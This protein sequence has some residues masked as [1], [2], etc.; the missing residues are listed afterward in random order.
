[1]VFFSSARNYY[2]MAEAQG[3]VGNKFPGLSGEAS[4]SLGF[5]SMHARPWGVS[6]SI[7]LKV[8]APESTSAYSAQ[9]NCHWGHD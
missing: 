7:R 4:H 8:L 9:W 5:V 2:F 3:Y 1:V 6:P